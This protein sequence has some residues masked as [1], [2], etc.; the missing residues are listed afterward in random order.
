MS[1]L[2]TPSRGRSDWYLIGAGGFV[3]VLLLAFFLSGSQQ[4]LRKSPVGFD[5]LHA[6][7]AAEGHP[8][9]S[10]TG[11]WTSDPDMI[12]LRILP[13]FD[14]NLK[15]RRRSPTT[16]EELLLQSDEY[17]LSGQ[18]VR[19][20]VEIVPTILVLPKWRSGMR[21]TGLAHPEI[22]LDK[23]AATDLLHSLFPRSIG[24]VSVLAQ[25]FTDFD[26]AQDTGG[27]TARLYAAQVFEGKGCTP[28]IGRAGEMVLGKCS[29]MTGN[30]RQPVWVLSDPDLL[31]NHGLR[32]GAN[33]ELA[34]QVLLPLADEG[35]VMIDY[36]DK[37]WLVERRTGI[38]RERTWSDLL[39]F[40]AYPFSV[41]WVSG[42]L[43]FGLILW[44]AGA[45]YGPI[46]KRKQGFAAS[47]SVANTAAA[48]LMRLTEQDGAL[49]NDY[50]NVRLSTIAARNL[51][52]AYKNDPDAA[53]RFVRR[54]RP[55]L[56]D[57]LQDAVNL[58]RSQPSNLS[59][60]VAIDCIDR[61]E[62]IL[63]QLNDDT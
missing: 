56:I 20:K 53:F 55:D 27:Q 60:N 46:L 51:G 10:F 11:G 58:I 33:A 57:A 43:L 52:P 25:P 29:M 48:K 9:R 36:S 54:K 38:Q 44:R 12:G 37:V 61:F 19:R 50:A 23:S 2:N 24:S 40:F 26:L 39:Q 21:L 7:I 45:R 32:L 5:G 17:D 28:I 8:V 59:A 41:L 4:Q 47:K 42:F 49:L 16:K 35:T 22:L 13:L 6:W 34:K 31:N 3:L 18:V 15:D 30:S 1:G 63:E 14:T 62:N